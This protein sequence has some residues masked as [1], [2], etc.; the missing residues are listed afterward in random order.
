MMLSF[1]Y[2][3]HDQDSRYGTT[4]Y[5]AQQRIAFSQLTWDKTLKNHDLLAG[6]ALRYTF[7]DDNTP[8]TANADSVKTGKSS[9]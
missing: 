2:N 7:Y 6:A 3:N 5:I 9:G 1:S 4:S 8:A